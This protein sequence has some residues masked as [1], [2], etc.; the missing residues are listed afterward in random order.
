ME[1]GIVQLNLSVIC[2]YNEVA[3]SEDRNCVSMI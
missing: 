1:A 2:T 3:E